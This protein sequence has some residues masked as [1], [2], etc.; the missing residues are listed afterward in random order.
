[1]NF[2]ENCS[3]IIGD[4]TRLSHAYI[5]SGRLAETLAMAVVCSGRGGARPCMK[6]T[7]CGKSSRHIHPDVIVVDKLPDKREIVVDQ[8]RELKRDVIV[9]P[10]EAERKAYIVN[11]ADLMNLSAQNA[12]LQILEEPPPH[13]VF[14]LGTDNP[15]ALLPTV[16]SRCVNL[17]VRHE[18]KA[19]G[20]T[21]DE[22][23]DEFFSAAERGNASLA[24][25]MFRLEK[26]DKNEF[27]EF[28]SAARAQIAHRLKQT[29]PGG[30]GALCNITTRVGRSEVDAQNGHQP[31]VPYQCMARMEPVLAK[32]EEMFDLNVGAGHISGMIC[33]SIIN[34][35]QVIE[36]R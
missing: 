35:E 6:C 27:S 30:T 20:S 17:N 16:R 19:S 4:G 34:I 25:F 32:A 1:M 23:V 18:S 12:F 26:L 10:N 15:A 5:I 11:D 9:V 21:V 36:S 3:H 14:I 2:F 7:H 28:L 29:A 33:A 24:Q 8:L 13:V 22:I 31:K